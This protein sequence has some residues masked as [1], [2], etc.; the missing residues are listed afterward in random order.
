MNASICAPASR[1]GDVFFNDG[2]KSVIKFFLYRHR[3]LLNLPTMVIGTVVRKPDEVARHSM[4]KAVKLL[5]KS[6]VCI[7]YSIYT[8]YSQG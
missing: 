2:T 7:H 5:K 8:G 3:V 6:N 4:W 1:A